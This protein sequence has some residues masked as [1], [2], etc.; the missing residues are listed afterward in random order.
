M[1]K[2]DAGV[3]AE[4]ETSFEKLHANTGEHEHQK[5]SD[6]HDIADTFDCHDN[7]LYNVLQKKA[8]KIV[9]P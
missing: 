5:K 1:L 9:K 6:H 2:N 3:G 8:R 7:T 4:T